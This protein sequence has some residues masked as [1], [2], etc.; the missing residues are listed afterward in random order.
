MEA[1]K[2]TLGSWVSTE[3][4]AAMPRVNTGN[5]KGNMINR[6]RTTKAK[7]NWYGVL[8]CACVCVGM[9]VMYGATGTTIY[10]Y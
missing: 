4:Y 6:M 9:L 8:L 10:D 5:V 3:R 1:R 2:T 7:V